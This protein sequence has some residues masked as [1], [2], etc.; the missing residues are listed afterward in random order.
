MC[1]ADVARVLLVRHCESSGP[2]PEAPLTAVGH[3]QASALADFLTAH[4]VARVVSSSYL[5]AQQTI[6]PFAERARLAIELDAR[7]VERRLSPEPIPNWRDAVRL[8]FDDPDHRVPGGESGREALSR[9]RAALDELLAA[10]HGVVV[11]V[12]HGQLLSLVLHAIDPRFGHAEWESLSN[13]DVFALEASGNRVAF[14][15][16]WTPTHVAP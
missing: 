3:R 12:S 15:R 11:A 1:A 2:A 14:E 7:L 9:G 8:S 13:P 10:P 4:P 16:I 6:A 5:R